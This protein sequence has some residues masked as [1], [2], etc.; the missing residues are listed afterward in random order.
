MSLQLVANSK[1]A[2]L[3]VNQD[4]LFGCHRNSG[5]SHHLLE[6]SKE[7]RRMIVF[8]PVPIANYLG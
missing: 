8:L 7:G 6:G 1:L 2:I 3:G 5:L 4:E